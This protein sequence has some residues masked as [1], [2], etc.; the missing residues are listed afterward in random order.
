M[1]PFFHFISTALAA[2]SLDTS[3][4][5]LCSQEP[6]NQFEVPRV[7]PYRLTAHLTSAFAI[8][9]T[10]VWTTLS[11]VTPQASTAT[12]THAVQQGASLLR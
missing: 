1:I 11:I 6:K 4:C 8:Y 7:S 2:C 10:L 5:C 12:A 9:A 3:H